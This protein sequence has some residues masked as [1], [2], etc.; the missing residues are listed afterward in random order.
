[1]CTHR[2]TTCAIKEL[3]DYSQMND[4]T[5]Y[6][7]QCTQPRLFVIIDEHGFVRSCVMLLSEAVSYIVFQ[8]KA[9]SIKN[10]EE[11]ES[12]YLYDENNEKQLISDEGAFQE[13]IMDNYGKWDGGIS[14]LTIRSVKCYSQD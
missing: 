5:H 9:Y 2:L 8:V 6:H 13:C 10:G 7:L 12:L 4:L 14:S 3:C 1:M 11:Y